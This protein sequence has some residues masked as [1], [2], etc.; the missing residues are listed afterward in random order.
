[1]AQLS[2]VRSAAGDHV[3]DYAD[4]DEDF[5]YHQA[6]VGDEQFGTIAFCYDE[7]MACRFRDDVVRR[8]DQAADRLQWALD[9]RAE[10]IR[11]ELNDE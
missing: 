9:A 3:D 2:Q 8:T 1:M 5:E 11:D 10:Q 4:I 7:L 6:L